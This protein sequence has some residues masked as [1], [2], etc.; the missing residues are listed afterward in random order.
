MMIF[1]MNC[2]TSLW[3]LYVQGKCNIWA[4]CLLHHPLR[5][6]EGH[7]IVKDDYRVLRSN[8]ALVRTV[9]SWIA[10]RKAVYRK[11]LLNINH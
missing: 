1:P 2:V 7:P 3:P 5:R 6:K 4:Y 11:K 9:E 10:Q 8:E